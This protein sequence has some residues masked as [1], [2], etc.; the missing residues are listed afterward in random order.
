MTVCRSKL[1]SGGG[2]ELSKSNNWWSV[3]VKENIAARRKM[4]YLSSLCQNHIQWTL[5]IM[6]TF[7]DLS[8]KWFFIAENFTIL[9]KWKVWIKNCCWKDLE[10]INFLHKASNNIEFQKVYWITCSGPTLKKSYLKRKHDIS[11]EENIPESSCD[12]SS[13]CNWPT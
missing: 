12:L 11:I 4:L 2:K 3:I 7:Q 10:F 8:P 5:W 13:I 1:V 9:L 6:K